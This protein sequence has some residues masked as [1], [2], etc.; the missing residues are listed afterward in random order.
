MPK[1]RR[2]KFSHLERNEIEVRFEMQANR[3]DGG[4]VPPQDCDSALGFIDA[5][6]VGLRDPSQPGK[7]TADAVK[8]AAAVH[9]L[10]MMLNGR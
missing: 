7:I 6:A 3:V 1:I 9:G 4:S 5:L 8:A 2:V 10:R